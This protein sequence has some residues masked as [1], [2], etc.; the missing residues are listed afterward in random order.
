MEV[1]TAVLS[2]LCLVAAAAPGFPGDFAA[3][4]YLGPARGKLFDGYFAEI[5]DGNAGAAEG[6]RRLGTEISREAARTRARFL[7]AEKKEDVYYALLSLRNLLHEPHAYFEFPLEL[8]PEVK[9]I[10]VP[11]S[12]RPRAVSGAAMEIVLAGRFPG[13][14]EGAVLR[15]YNGHKPEEALHEYLEWHED[16]SRESLYAGFARWLT[17]RD[18]ERHPPFG[19]KRLSFLFS[20]PDG[21]NFEIVIPPSE[22][23]GTQEEEPDPKTREYAG[24]EPVDSGEQYDLFRIPGT[25]VLV[26]RYTSFLYSVNKA[27]EKSPVSPALRELADAGKLR[28]KL[29]APGYSVLLLDLRE[30]PG[31]QFPYG[32]LSLLSGKE[33]RLPYRR[34]AY[35]PLAL[36]DREFLRSFYAKG[37][38]PRMTREIEA[39]AVPGADLS[40]SFS[41][42]CADEACG[43]KTFLPEPDSDRREYRVYAL[44]GPGCASSCEQFLSVFRANA[45]GKIAGLPSRGSS[46]PFHAVRRFYLHDGT[47]FFIRFK[48]GVTFGPDGKALDAEPPRPDLYVFPQSDDGLRE[49]ISA[50]IADVPKD[51]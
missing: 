21:K 31:G 7:A 8:R 1:K 25:E 32:L 28:K 29:F 40:A 37:V 26:L 18:S 5:M 49:L 3:D 19:T 45:L 51:R 35:T 16:A 9:I 20:G 13:I 6:A 24:L 4:R 47:P 48:G 43:V 44:S 17:R 34:F 46:V 10:S 27:G 50:V 14:P 33:V 38:S 15:A 22:I 23:A 42:D 30:N 2:V 39:G 41:F 36:R 12:L 11:L